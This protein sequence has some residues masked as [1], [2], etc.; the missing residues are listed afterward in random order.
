MEPG[1][2][3]NEPWSLKGLNPRRQERRQGAKLELRPSLAKAYKQASVIVQRQEYDN[4]PHC[5]KI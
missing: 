3:K 4:M 2:K 1:L 5:D